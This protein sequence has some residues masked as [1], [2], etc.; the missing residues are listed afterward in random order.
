MTTKQRYVQRNGKRID[1]KTLLNA[2]LGFTNDTAQLFVGSTLSTQT[3]IKYKNINIEPFPNAIN[4]VNEVLQSSGIY[5][6]YYVTEHLM[7]ETESYEKATDIINYINH[8]V[9]IN[10]LKPIANYSTNIEIITE[11]NISDYSNPAVD[12]ISYNIVDKFNRPSKRLLS[13]ILSIDE[14][15]VFLT[16]NRNDA[17]YIEIKYSLSQ[18]NGQHKRTGTFELIGDANIDNFYDVGFNDNQVLLDNNLK[19]SDIRFNAT[20]VGDKVQILFEQPPTD[21][22]KIFYKI[23]IWGIDN[24]DQF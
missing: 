18:N 11:N 1:L 17:T 14:G 7:I 16:F 2:E 8:Q 6:M 3:H 22:T 21:I 9:V 5:S 4:Y 23:S 24:I 20:Y 15:N 13:K 19:D 12:N 10:G